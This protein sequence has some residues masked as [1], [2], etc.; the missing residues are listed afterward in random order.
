MRLLW[1]GLSRRGRGIDLDGDGM[2]GQGDIDLVAMLAVSVGGGFSGHGWR[3]VADFGGG[4]VKRY[5]ALAM[6]VL[7]G[8]VALGV[9]SGVARQ[10]RSGAGQFCAYDVVIESGVGLGAWQ[11]EVR[12]AEGMEL[13]GVEVATGCIARRRITT[14]RR[15]GRGGW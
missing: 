2:I 3:G 8:A 14:R 12:C 6:L 1:L 13:T 15:C 10:G 9:Q 4:T 7:V 11:V 5:G